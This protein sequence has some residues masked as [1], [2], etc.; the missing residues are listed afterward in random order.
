MILEIFFRPNKQKEKFILS[1]NIN[2]TLYLIESTLEHYQIEL[3]K[4][5][6]LDSVLLYGFLMSFLKFY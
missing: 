3:V 1:N 6:N 4:N 5:I 2:D